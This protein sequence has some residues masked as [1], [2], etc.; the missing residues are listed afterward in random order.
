MFQDKRQTKKRINCM[1]QTRET[2]TYKLLCIES[3]VERIMSCCQQRQ[4]EL[5]K[6]ALKDVNLNTDT[7]MGIGDEFNIDEKDDIADMECTKI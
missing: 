4:H 1:T 3:A 6:N 2:S 5:F 7:Q